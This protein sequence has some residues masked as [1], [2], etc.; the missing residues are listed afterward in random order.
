MREFA[1]VI[2]TI[3]RVC[4]LIA[5][6]LLIAYV[7]FS[8]V[9]DFGII[10][11]IVSQN[12]LYNSY[13]TDF[14]ILSSSENKDFEKELIAFAEKSNIN[15]SIEYAGNLEIIEILN[16]KGNEYDAVWN[17][18]AI[19]NYMLDDT[20]LLSDS[21]SVST[22]P[23]VF[24]VKK[25]KAEE[26]GFVGR[27]IY[28]ADIVNAISSGN[29][30]FSMSN[31]AQTN[32]GA[33]T[34]LGLLSVFSGS[35]E[36]LKTE[37]LQNEEMKNTLVNFFG[38]LDRSSGSE[39][40]LEEIVLSNQEFDVVATYEF[41]VINMNKNLIESGQEP[42]YVLYPEDGI[43]ISD[44]PFSYIDNDNELKKEAYDILKKYLI[45]NEG[46]SKLAALG[47]R[48][49]YGG[50]N[51]NVNIEVFNPEWGIDT[52]RYLVPIKYPHKDIIKDALGLYQNEL[53]KP[54]VVVFCLDYSG[55]MQGNGKQQLIS[56]MEYV[57]NEEK[58]SKDYVQ[59]REDDI[60]Y[61][62]PF[63]S[64]VL[65]KWGPVKGNNTDELLSTI[66][67]YKPTGSTNIYDT[68][69]EALKILKDYDSNKYG[70]SVI[71]MTDG[72]SNRG[73]YL[74]LSEFYRR[75]SL[76]IPV[77]SIEFG[78]AVEEELIQI[79]TLTNGKKFD[80]KNDLVKAFRKVRG[81]N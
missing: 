13:G 24:A 37:H 68:T 72:K 34:Y 73:D 17:S 59:F 64:Y 33:S 41:S 61:I 26:L 52:E 36:V 58:A 51:S 39:D 19:W 48:T 29:L 10:K 21:V 5:A 67:E 81:Y 27:E 32:S 28:N 45:S 2:N 60:I 31:P 11:D 71:L 1:N 57:L 43:S 40:Y 12:G 23:V 8:N 77:F 69:V 44:S 78:E 47:R 20:A 7:V 75:N 50:I 56:A 80:G 49:W 76:N 70:R 18:N 63:S 62:L 30:K 35:P 25:S 14:R 22:N 42:F 6:F 79:E 3:I 54:M 65:D 16:D 66:K 15:L 53:R 9:N 4:F 55:S 74:T 38:A 46:K